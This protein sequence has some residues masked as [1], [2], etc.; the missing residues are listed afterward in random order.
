L[1]VNQ[2]ASQPTSQI[3]KFYLSTNFLCISLNTIWSTWIVYN[4]QISKH[5]INIFYLSFIPVLL[6]I[7][8]I[9]LPD[10]KI[11]LLL[12][13]YRLHHDVQTT[14]KHYENFIQ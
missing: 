14:K 3:I 4:S 5:T 10:S 6:K 7:K 13:Y 1:L 2:P 11:S 12:S 8:C 9:L